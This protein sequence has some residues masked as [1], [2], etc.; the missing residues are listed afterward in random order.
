MDLYQNSKIKIHEE[1]NE[2]LYQTKQTKNN[3]INPTLNKTQTRNYYTNTIKP[4]PK[5]K[6][7]RETCLLN[8]ISTVDLETINF[9]NKQTPI[10]ISLAY[11]IRE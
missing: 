9:N 5:K 11:I 4:L 6:I 8:S 10:S 1:I 3:S 7:D 2:K